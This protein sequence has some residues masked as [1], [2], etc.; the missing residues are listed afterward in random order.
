V[1]WARRKRET[2]DE[3]SWKSRLSRPASKTFPIANRWRLKR[4]LRYRMHRKYR[5]KP[6]STWALHRRGAR[7]PPETFQS[8]LWPAGYIEMSYKSLIVGYVGARP[9]T[10]RSLSPAPQPVTFTQYS[11]AS[12][13]CQLP[14][15]ATIISFGS[16]SEMLSN[17]NAG[18]TTGA[19][20][21][22]RSAAASARSSNGQSG[23]SGA[24]STG[25]PASSAQ[26]M[27]VYMTWLSTQTGGSQGS[28]GTS[29]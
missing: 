8:A 27:E 2:Y 7:K 4:R 11:I 13:R 6:H 19:N 25:T 1:I 26:P 15:P 3:S 9:P 12:Y 22:T 21:V 10:L 14:L 20:V 24:G 17:P 5:P 16:P 18:S 28:G 23:T 29:G